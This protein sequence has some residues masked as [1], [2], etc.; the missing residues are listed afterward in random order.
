MTQSSLS[1]CASDASRALATGL[2]VAHAD[3][4]P[5][6]SPHHN[7]QA[8]ADPVQQPRASSL[9]EAASK[10]AQAQ[11]G[12]HTTKQHALSVDEPVR[13]RDGSHPREG[14]WPAPLRVSMAAPAESVSLSG[15]R[16]LLAFL[17]T[18]A[19]G[20][21]SFTSKPIPAP[22]SLATGTLYSSCVLEHARAP[23]PAVL[24]RRPTGADLQA[25]HNKQYAAVAAVHGGTGFEPEARCDS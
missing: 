9:Q 14:R 1:F 19:S 22:F 12:A 8:E 18:S 10:R 11:A 4:V 20:S 25:E 3:T 17:T 23:T 16:M 6:H 21:A 5:L 24:R 13:H 7:A 15:L 2:A